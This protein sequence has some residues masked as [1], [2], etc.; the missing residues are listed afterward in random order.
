MKFGYSVISASMLGLFATVFAGSVYRCPSTKEIPEE[1]ANT[2]VRNELARA[3]NGKNLKI[4]F[5]NIAV[6][7][8]LK[9]SLDDVNFK[10]MAYINTQDG[11]FRVFEERSRPQSIEICRLVV[12]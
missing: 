9:Y 2:A 5:D 1:T 8:L 4:I 3:D 12:R 11:T 10:I 6:M 7:R